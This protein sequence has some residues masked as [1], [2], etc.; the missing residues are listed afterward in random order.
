MLEIW[1]DLL[2]TRELSEKKRPKRDLTRSLIRNKFWLLLFSGVGAATIG[3]AVAAPT[4]H[5]SWNNWEQSVAVE[6]RKYKNIAIYADCSPEKK[7]GGDDPLIQII[8]HGNPSPNGSYVVEVKGAGGVDSREY[9]LNTVA[10]GNNEI[11]DW[12]T[13]PINRVTVRAGAWNGSILAERK[14][15]RCKQA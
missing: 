1:R 3:C 14:I 4:I 11:I 9:T 7:R 10:L 13:K 8:R 2:S 12:G 15:D 6:A 5:Q